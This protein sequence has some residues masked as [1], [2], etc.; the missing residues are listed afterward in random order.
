MAGVQRRTT[1]G[2]NC[3]SATENCTVTVSPTT[4]PSSNCAQSSRAREAML[5]GP[6]NPSLEPRNAK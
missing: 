3:Q 5:L 2:T 6:F 4:Q 1:T